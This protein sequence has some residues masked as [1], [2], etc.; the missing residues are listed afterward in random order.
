MIGTRVSTTRTRRVARENRREFAIRPRD[1]AK[2]PSCSSSFILA[3]RRPSAGLHSLHSARRP[4]PTSCL[5]SGHLHRRRVGVLPSC[6][7]KSSFCRLYGVCGLRALVIYVV[8]VVVHRTRAQC[9]REIETSGAC[10]GVECEA[11]IYNL[12]L[13]FACRLSRFETG[14]MHR[15]LVTIWVALIEIASLI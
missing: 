10:V 11:E 7:T 4:Q 14:N 5:A 1:G 9:S 13:G 8:I 2:F 12:Q 3:L 15:L 6:I